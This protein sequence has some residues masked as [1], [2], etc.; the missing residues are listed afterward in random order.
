MQ[1]YTLTC[2]IRL[3]NLA[4]ETLSHGGYFACLRSAVVG[5]PPHLITKL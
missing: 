3:L 4:N 2:I 5:G 1:F